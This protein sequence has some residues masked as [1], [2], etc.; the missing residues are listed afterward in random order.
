[1]TRS[2]F[3]LMLVLATFGCST[4]PRDAGFED[5][6]A[7]AAERTGYHPVWFRD[8]G[9]EQVAN[10]AV[11]ALLSDMLTAEEA[12]QVAL[13]SNRRLQVTLARLGIAR[14]ALIQAGLLENPVFDGEVKFFDEGTT[15]EATLTQS[16]LSILYLPL[17]RAVAEERFEAEKLRVAAEVI[18]LIGSVKRAY[19]EHQ[20]DKQLVEMMRAVVQA[21]EGSY[22]AALKLREAGNLP[23]LEVLRERALYEQAKVELN[24][25]VERLATSREGLNDLMGLWGERTAW[26]TPTRLPDLPQEEAR[27]ASHAHGI[28]GAADAQQIAE[29]IAG[30]PVPDSIAAP[31]TQIS[32]PDAVPSGFDEVERLAIKRSLQLATSRQ[33]IR[34][35]AAALRLNVGQALFADGDMG[36]AAERE[37]EGE[38]GVGPA[39]GFSIPLFDFG[40]GAR[41]AYAGQLRQQINEYAALAVRTR[42]AA[43]AAQAR[44]ITTRSRAVYYRDVILPL[45]AALV[46]QAQ[47]QFNAMQIGVFQLL[48]AKRQQ[49]DAGR[50]YVQALREYWLARTRL[51]QLLDGSM[52]EG[53]LPGTGGMRPGLDGLEIYGT[54][55]GEGGH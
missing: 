53:M 42:A 10:T 24:E 8:T 5:V 25:A 36:V 29:K 2:A 44:L 26:E 55:G 21:T 9:D 22:M 28:G 48:E 17:R 45:N 46:E 43:R 33:A 1:M 18:D 35:L 16:V 54:G 3:P 51:E 12:V 47:R 23:P 20:A 34:A 52:P 15:F 31:A 49:I 13:L 11:G 50:N 7:L 37:T 19:W 14:A 4:A 39:F 27:A 38:W 6:R 32:D 40:Q 41:A 30:A